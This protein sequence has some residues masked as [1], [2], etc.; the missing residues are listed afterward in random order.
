MEE[1]FDGVWDD[2]SGGWKEGQGEVGWEF[3]EKLRVGVIGLL[4]RDLGGDRE[5][6]DMSGICVGLIVVVSLVGGCLGG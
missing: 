5:C 4:L 1:V 3:W 2:E 6:L